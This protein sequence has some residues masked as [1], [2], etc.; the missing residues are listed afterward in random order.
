MIINPAAT[1]AEYDELLAML[2]ELRA[3]LRRHWGGSH[4]PAVL[5]ALENA[6]AGSPR[7]FKTGKEI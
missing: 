4:R 1:Q 7:E 2:A 3:A 5:S 6:V